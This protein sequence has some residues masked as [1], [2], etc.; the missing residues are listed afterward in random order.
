MLYQS[1]MTVNL[2]KYNEQYTASTLLATTKTFTQEDVA[3]DSAKQIGH[4]E[5]LQLLK[6]DELPYCYV[7]FVYDNTK[8]ICVDPFAGNEQAINSKAQEYTM[9]QEELEDSKLTGETGSLPGRA[10]TSPADEGGRSYGHK[11]TDYLNLDTATV[12]NVNL[13]ITQKL[14]PD[15][16]ITED[17]AYMKIKFGTDLYKYKYMEENEQLERTMAPTVNQQVSKRTFTGKI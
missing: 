16:S 4:Y 12:E 8:Y 5:F 3:N 6:Q 2:Y 15:F 9:K 10:I 13:G 1:G 14:E 17:V 11:L 7:E